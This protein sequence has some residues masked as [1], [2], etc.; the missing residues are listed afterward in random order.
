MFD[1]LHLTN[2][3]RSEVEHVPETGLP[4]DAFPDKIQ[5][6]ILNL[7]RYENFNTEYTASIIL[8]AVA[9]AVGN[10]C[11]IRIKGEWKTSPSLYM[12]LI[13]RPGLGKTPPLGFIYKPINKQD[14]KMFEKYN[15]EWKEYERAMAVL[16]NKREKEADGSLPKK[17]HLVTTVISDFTPEAMMNTHQYNLRGIALVVDEI[18]ALFSSVRR[19]SNKNNL[20]EDLLTA[21]SGQPLKI[22]RKSE[23]R[24][25]LIKKPC[26]NLIGSIQT[27]LLQEVFRTE[28]LANGLLD[29]FL[30]VYPK[31][32]TI[33]V[34]KRNALALASARPDILNQWRT[35]LNK[36]LGIPCDV[37]EKENSVNPGILTMTADAEEYFYDWYNRI[38]DS[39]NAIENDAEVESRKMK[40]NGHAAR[41]ALLFQIMKWAVDEADMQYVELSSVKAAIR[42]LDYYEE[43]Y[44]RIQEIIVSDSIGETK[45][46]WFLLLGDTF[47]TCDAIV[48]GKKVEMSRRTVYYALE[49]LCRLQNPLIEKIHHGVYRKTTVGNANAPCTIA[50]SS[51]QDTVQSS[52]SATVQSATTLKPENHE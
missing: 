23:L 1:N 37:N 9:T 30:F 42:M 8:S 20:I 41:L 16:G 45:E 49:Q 12:M 25:I 7:S 24:P 46:A 32:R 22:I 31:D 43:T 44:R 21:Y 39:V 15:E 50:L 48:A 33:S 4:L 18:L 40:L 29:R 11:Q 52:Q 10:S 5:E 47:S 26:I 28:F 38:I 17:P 36:I 13:G 6:I 27:N 3:L 14:D 19:Y 34:W 35:I 51:C 2:M